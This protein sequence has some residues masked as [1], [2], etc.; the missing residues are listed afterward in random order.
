[1]LTISVH[2]HRGC[3]D[4]CGYVEVWDPKVLALKYRDMLEV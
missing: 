4:V 2:S 1:M 3:G